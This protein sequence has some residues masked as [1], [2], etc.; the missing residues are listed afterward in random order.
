MCSSPPPDG[1]GAKR[2]RKRKI[3]VKAVGI[4][5]AKVWVKKV[6]YVKGV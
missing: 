5:K 1:R 3:R 6:W 4:A 2:T